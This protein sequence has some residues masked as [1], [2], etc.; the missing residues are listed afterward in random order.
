[1]KTD[2]I[3]KYTKQ[4]YSYGIIKQ[5]IEDYRGIC[6]IF[7]TETPEDFI[8]EFHLPKGADPRITYEFTNYLVELMCADK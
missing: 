1:M 4:I 7:A 8:C 3:V 5:A 6:P 2:S